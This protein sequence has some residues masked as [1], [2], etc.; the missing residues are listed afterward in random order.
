MATGLLWYV[1]AMAEPASPAVG[2]VLALA[3][4]TILF[5]KLFSYRDVNL[6]C[7]QRRARAKAGEAG[8]GELVWGW[9]WGAQPHPGIESV[10]LAVS[11]G[12]KA[13]GATAQRTVS[14]PDNLT[15]RGEDLWGQVPGA[16]DRVMVRGK[17]VQVPAPTFPSRSLLFYFCPYSVLRTQLSSLPPNSKTL[18]AAAAP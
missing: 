13:S 1:G 5:L 14:Y 6:W 8:E 16:G 3:A 18:P 17:S 11:A 9:P 7:R 4:Y 15:Y 10:L 2:S 12:K